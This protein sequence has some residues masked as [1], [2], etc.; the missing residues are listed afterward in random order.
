MRAR[1]IEG[2]GD[3][4]Q[5]G[6]LTIRNVWD[7]RPAADRPGHRVRAISHP[8]LRSAVPEV[9]FALLGEGGHAFLLVFE[10]AKS[11][12]EQPPLEL[13]ALGERR[14]V[15]AVDQPPWP[16]SRQWRRERG[17]LRGRPP[18][19]RPAGS[20]AGTTRLTRPQRSASAASIVRPVSTM[21]MALDLPTKRVRRWVPPAPGMMPM[22]DLRLAELARYRPRG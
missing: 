11:G 6:R 7:G 13:H 3:K 16:S 1:F 2:A 12:V 17:D 22:V 18:G 20:A 5:G 19:P 14:L 21:S 8:V 9:G 15:G 4:V 10:V